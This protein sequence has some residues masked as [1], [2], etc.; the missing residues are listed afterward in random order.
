[1]MFVAIS[2]VVTTLHI[3]SPGRCSDCINIFI[4]TSAALTAVIAFGIAETIY[5]KAPDVIKKHGTRIGL[6]TDQGS[7]FMALT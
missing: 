7:K 2:L 4:S 6:G 5:G 3:S 1:M